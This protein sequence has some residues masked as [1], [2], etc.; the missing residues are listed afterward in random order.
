MPVRQNR[1]PSHIGHVLGG[2]IADVFEQTSPSS[3]PPRL[4]KVAHTKTSW[5]EF[6]R[7]AGFQ[8]SQLNMGEKDILSLLDRVLIRGE[9]WH[10]KDRAKL[11][12]RDIDLIPEKLCKG[13]AKLSK[14]TY[15]RAIDRLIKI[16]LI[17][18]TSPNQHGPRRVTAAWWPD[19]YA[20]D[21]VSVWSRASSL[22]ADLKASRSHYDTRTSQSCHSNDTRPR[23]DKKSPNH[24]DS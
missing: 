3:C 20:Y 4:S 11:T 5:R 18:V 1:H 8:V 17:L 16:G 12:R 9:G 21:P 10:S 6:A 24:P 2:I 19:E 23:P 22:L 15:Q 7:E 14:R 13:G